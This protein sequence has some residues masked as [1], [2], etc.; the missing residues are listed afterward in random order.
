M[1]AEPYICEYMGHKALTPA[2]HELSLE[3]SLAACHYYVS[4]NA[5]TCSCDVTDPCQSNRL[6]ADVF[7]GWSETRSTN[8]D[9][10]VCLMYQPW[11]MDDYNYD[12]GALG[13]VND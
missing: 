10:I 12:Y 1:F 6:L 7:F 2:V 9:S 3:T 13:E 8:T 4:T 5:V 11:M